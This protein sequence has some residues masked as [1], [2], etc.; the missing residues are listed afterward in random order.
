M[1][2]IEQY[3]NIGARM[4]DPDMPAAFHSLEERLE[5]LLKLRQEQINQGQ[6]HTQE[7]EEMLEIKHVRDQFQA[8]F[9]VLKD[10]KKAAVH[11]EEIIHS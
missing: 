4:P 11:G 1:D 8:L 10:M 9:T 7:R 5:H 2:Q 6:G 3:V